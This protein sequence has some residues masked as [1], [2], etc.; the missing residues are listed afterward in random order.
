[1]KKQ[2]ISKKEEVVLDREFSFTHWSS[3][4]FFFRTSTLYKKSTLIQR[5]LRV[6]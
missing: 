6:F 1:M 2:I 5:F 4:Y 3:F